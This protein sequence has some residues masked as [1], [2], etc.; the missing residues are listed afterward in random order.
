MEIDHP[1]SISNILAMDAILR[2]SQRHVIVT[3]LH[4]KLYDTKDRDNASSVP[5]PGNFEFR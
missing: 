1:S 5:V 3:L 4:W 2:Q